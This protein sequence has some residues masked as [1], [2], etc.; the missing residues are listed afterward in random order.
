ML[1]DVAR[2]AA[3]PA[4]TTSSPGRIV[5]QAWLA[6]RGLIVAV[7]LLLAVVQH[8]TLTNM[9]SNWDVQHFARLAT[10]GY[11]SEPNGTLMAFFPGWPLIL[12]LFAQLGVPVVISG[13]ILSTAF[14]A[15]A[16][17]ALY[18]LGGPW[19]AVA[20]LFAPTARLH[21]GGLHRVTVLR[22]RFLGLGARPCRSLVSRR[23]A[24]GSRVHGTR[25]RA[26]PDRRAPRDDLYQHQPDWSQ[27]APRSADADADVGHHGFCDVSVC[28][29]RE[30]DGLVSRTDDRL[31]ARADLA[32]AVLL[33]HNPRRLAGRV[34]QS[35]VVGRRCSAAR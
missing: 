12:S 3:A 11:F 15:V 19:A 16:A 14:S 28:P 23:R 30:L 18:R 29:H 31:G 20:W 26:F 10:G 25:V 8:R 17:A 2:P 32:L 21:D 33:E 27:A 22:R 1:Q 9:V 7:A 35:S 6:S 4:E 24:Y 34:R 13:V 5:I